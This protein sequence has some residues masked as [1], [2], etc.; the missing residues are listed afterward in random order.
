MGSKRI[1]IRLCLALSM[2]LLALGVPAAHAGPTGGWPA[3]EEVVAFSTDIPAGQLDYGPDGVSAIESSD[4]TYSGELTDV[5]G[6]SGDA[7]SEGGSTDG[8]AASTSSS[9]S[10]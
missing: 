4:S 8:S 6:E 3:E 7:G 5:V 2:T 10:S 9:T 1:L